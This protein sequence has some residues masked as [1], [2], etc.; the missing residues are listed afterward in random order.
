MEF[1]VGIQYYLELILY[2]MPESRFAPLIKNL[3]ISCSYF[4]ELFE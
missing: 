4:V 2:E 3:T 1:G